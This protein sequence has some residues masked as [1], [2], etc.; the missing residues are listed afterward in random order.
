MEDFMNIIFNTDPK[1]HFDNLDELYD[2][3]ES[4]N[5]AC[6]R[7]EIRNV[8]VGGNNN[9][10]PCIRYQTTIKM[11]LDHVKQCIQLKQKSRLKQI[12]IEELELKKNKIENRFHHTN[13]QARLQI[14]SFD[15]QISMKVQELKEI[16]KQLRKYIQEGEELMKLSQELKP[17]VQELIDKYGVEELERQRFLTMFKEN[18][19]NHIIASQLSVPVR[20]V[21][22]IRGLENKE[23]TAEIMRVA[24]EAL[25]QKEKDNQIIQNTI[26]NAGEE[27]EGNI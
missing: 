3:F 5:D 15:I 24:F 1:K 16:L 10:L 12:E 17:A 27:N 25:L 26:K 9:I 20:L 22:I 7:Y 21:E 6:S 13:K 14:E 4:L 19:R 23:D 18:I 8:V 11:L 2:L